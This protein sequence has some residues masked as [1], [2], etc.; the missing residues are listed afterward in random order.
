MERVDFRRIA[1]G[2]G[3]PVLFGLGWLVLAGSF[4]SVAQLGS[5]V[6]LF[7]LPNGL[8]VG[9]LFLL[10]QKR[11]PAVLLALQGVGT[12]VNAAVGMLPV[13]ALGLAFANL[14]EATLVAVLAQRIFRG[15]RLDV[16]QLS[17]MLRFTLAAFAGALASALIALLFR[18]D[19]VTLYTFCWWLITVML[20]TLIA[21][22]IFL[23]L[24]R[25]IR[26]RH[27]VGPPNNQRERSTGILVTAGAVFL[28]SFG[29]LSFETIQLLFLP[30]AL[31]VLAV[32]RH[33]PLGAAA[34]VLAFGLA[35]T[36]RSLGGKSPAAF[37]AMEPFSAGFVLQIFM[38]VQIA[39]AIPLAALMIRHDRFA[40]R[41]ALRAERLSE[42]LKILSLAENVSGIGHWHVDLRTSRHTLS[43]QMYHL[44]G[45]DTHSA[46]PLAEMRRLLPEG[47]R[48]LLRHSARHRRMRHPFGFAF[49]LE[50]GTGEA[51]MLRIKIRADFD[52]QGRRVALF[53]VAMDI[54]DQVA[55][56]R[57]LEQARRSA[58]QLA[59]EAQRLANT[60]ALTGLANRRSTFGHLD[61][62]IQSSGASG[63][64]LSIVTFDLDH[65]KQI[66]DCF[67]HQMGD[68]VLVR[69]AHIARSVAREGDLIGRTGGEEFIW[70][71]PGLSLADAGELAERLRR[72]IARE[73][74][75][76]EMPRVT[77]SVGV[78]E[79]LVGEDKFA[80]VSRA[81]EALY[82]AKNSGRNRIRQAA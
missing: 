35:A 77:T 44:L 71:L 1:E 16:L 7:W 18:Q 48:T 46:S 67:G 30:M 78:A 55:R 49:P 24:V 9:T 21:T 61:N 3:M 37:L 65:F 68:K 29:V 26:M 57:K 43:P 69:T 54:T 64:R 51:R 38:L 79:W 63:E 76:T 28:V 33:G 14:A 56:E 60:D 52:R 72:T 80:L 34:G 11:W 62:L 5:A 66:N 27:R 82:E 40:R 12:L 4:M 23:H 2:P 47:W 22:P 41:L 50:R 15:K 8:A 25:R 20:G 58:L 13:V 36:A 6:N 17:E 74:G 81:D 39:C 53:A 31:T 75:R 10:P 59:D 42:S 73:S 32:V 45:L 70:L 19:D